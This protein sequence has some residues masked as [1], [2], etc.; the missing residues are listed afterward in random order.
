MLNTFN[1]AII[2]SP[3]KLIK[4]AFSHSL[5]FKHHDQIIQSQPHLLLQLLLPSRR[6]KLQLQLQHDLFY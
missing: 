5:S 6:R 3:Y 4:H 2:I 1:I